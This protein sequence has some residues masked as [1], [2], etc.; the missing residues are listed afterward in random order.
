MILITES[1]N[2]YKHNLRFKGFGTVCCSSIMDLSK[3]LELGEKYGLQGEKLLAF[4]CEERDKEYS[5]I[6]ANAARDERQQQREEV[7][8]Q[9]QE[10]TKQKQI[11]LQIAECNKDKNKCDAPGFQSALPRMQAFNADSDDLDAYILRFERHAT[12]SKWPRGAWAPALGNLLTGSA[13]D[14]YTRLPLSQA[15]DYDALK[16]ALLQHFTLTADGFR[17]R[18]RETKQ[19]DGESFAQFAAR[20]SG[21]THRWVELS[22]CDDSFEA[23]LDLCIRE[24]LLA[25]CTREL[26]IFIRE[27]TPRDVQEFV[28][29]AERYFEARGLNDQKCQPAF[30]NDRA[31]GPRCH[32]CGRW[33]HIAPKCPTRREVPPKLPPKP[34]APGKVQTG[35]SCLTGI[36]PETPNCETESAKADAILTAKLMCGHEL[37]VLNS[38]CELG[39]E[40]MPTSQGKVNGRN[41]TVLRDTGC[42][43]VVVRK[44]LVDDSQ[45]SGEFQPCIL[46]DGTVRRFPIAFVDVHTPYFTGNVKALCMNNPVYDLIIGNVNGVRM[47]DGVE[48]RTKETSGSNVKTAT[49]VD[50][51]D[52]RRGVDV[53]TQTETGTD[54]GVKETG[55]VMESEGQTMDSTTHASIGASVET[56]GMKRKKEQPW[57]RLKTPDGI[58]IAATRDEMLQE[59]RRDVTLEKVKRLAESGESKFVGK[60]GSVRYFYENSLLYRQYNSPYVENGKVFKQLV[61]PKSLRN[62]VLQLAHDMPLAGHLQTKKTLDRVMS[63]FY[64]PGIQSDVKRYCASCDSC[65]RTTPKGRVGKVPLVTPQLIDTCF[66]RVA[67]DIIGPL[68]PITDKGNRYILTLVD[69]ATRYPEAV[70]LPSIEAERVAE[71]LMEVF[72]R[73]GFPNEMLSDN[74]TQFTAGVMREA[75]RLVGVRQFYTTPYHPMANGACER[76]NG[77]LKQMLRRMCQERPKDWD[78]YLPALLFSY[79]EV[80]HASTGY[81]PFELMYGR[82]VRGPMTILKELWT[83]EITEE[84]VKTTYQYVLDLKER[85]EST[86]EVAKSVLEK[87]SLRYK[88]H[89]DVKAR[90]RRFEEGDKVLLL[91]PTC[92]NKLQMQWQGPFEVVGR[93]A[94]HNYKLQVR[95]KVKTYHANLMKKYVERVNEESVTQA[96]HLSVA[97][98]EVNEDESASSEYP[99]VRQTEDVIGV[100][101]RC[102]DRCFRGRHWNCPYAR[103]RRRLVPG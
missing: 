46:M 65:Q 68:Q 43:A 18:F 99:S 3:F 60:G 83:E 41:V 64:W 9:Q 70:A 27:R 55:V 93:V 39:P 50:T 12:L 84:E 30:R 14:C 100:H 44:S 53:E 28:K 74:G 81:S 19:K 22:E 79:R 40:N 94:R 17:K 89:F 35:G 5:K 97:G 2:G 26:A 88:K 23:V 90:D 72:S 95:G 16:H 32:S 52:T 76:F 59:Q 96:N 34:P 25:C 77:T 51:E 49:E 54:G 29:H 66:R 62:S 33:G 24:Q 10:V 47:S 87:S 20:V 101:I 8:K 82:V 45:V 67:V 6:E 103:T 7:I 58:E 80:P 21:Y 69:L 98:E 86:C 38:G 73:L 15:E 36:C 37:L 42:N 4:A 75:A 85:L 78:R 57:R 11:E 48:G 31:Q 1:C 92:S 63:Q 102:E 61:V 71:G 13:L 56:R 91:L